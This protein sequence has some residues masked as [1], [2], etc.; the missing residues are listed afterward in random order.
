MNKISE[1]IEDYDWKEAF[2]YASNIR[3]A[4]NCSNNSFN[5]E[6]VICIIKESEGQNDGESWMMVG[7]LKDNRFFFLDAWCDYTGWDCQSSGD[8]QVADTLENLIRFGMT[9]EA[10]ERLNLQ[11]PGEMIST[12]SF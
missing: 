6:D 9:E 2:G 4:T 8:A 1:I 3:T 5:I 10:R 11:I 7:Q 12:L